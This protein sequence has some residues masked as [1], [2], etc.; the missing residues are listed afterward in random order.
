MVD[1][2][3]IFKKIIC[4]IGY[5]SLKYHPINMKKWKNKK[6]KRRNFF[7]FNY[8]TWDLS[9][10][11]EMRANIMGQILDADAKERCDFK[12]LKINL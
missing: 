1:K 10:M 2:N 5:F 4:I 11:E 9:Q 7:F 3:V 12:S 6:N 8:W